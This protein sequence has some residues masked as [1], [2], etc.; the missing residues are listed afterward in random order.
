MRLLTYVL[1]FCS[2]ATFSQQDSLGVKK[3]PKVGLVLSGGGAKGLAHIGALK[4]IEESGVHIDYIGGTSM[5]AIIGGLYASGYTATQLDSI[6]R[7]T[8]FDELIQD[9]LPRSAKSF[10]ERDDAE[11]YAITLP[12]DKFEVSLPSGLSKG[13][14][15]Y[16]YLERLTSHLEDVSD[17]SKL[18]IPFFCVG[19]DVETGETL[20]LEKGSISKSISA[21]GAIPTLFNPVLIDDR[22]IT[23]GGVTNNYPLDEL[24]AKGMDIIIGVDVQ[25][26][27]VSRNELKS[28]FEIL[29]QVNNFE[30]IYKMRDKSKRTDVYINPDIK[31]FTV[32]SFGEGETIVKRGEDAAM[33]KYDKLR[34]IAI[35][36]GFKQ[37]IPQRIGLKD[38]IIIKNIIISGNRNYPRGY[39]K[40]R[41]KIPDEEKIAFQDLNYG[42]NNL[43]ATGNFDRIDYVLKP[44][45]DGY[46]VR[47]NVDESNNSTLLR[48]SL[49]YDD[50]YQTG[51]L[52]NITQKRL[53]FGNDIASL[54]MIVG[55]NLRYNFEYYIDKGIYW[56]I[57]ARSRIN[58]FNRD[59]NSGFLL[60]Q[61]EAE[62]LPSLLINEFELDV[63]DFT[64]QIYAET[65]FRKD[66]KIGVG[67]EQKYITLETQTVADSDESSPEIET[68]NFTS[69][70]GYV[71]LD[72]YDDKYFPN[73]GFFAEGKYNFYAFNSADEVLEFED[74]SIAKGVLGMAINPWDPVAI[75]LSTEAGFRLGSNENLALN[76]ALGGYGSMMINNYV[77]FYGYDFLSLQGDSYIK[78][79]GEIDVELFPKNHLIASYNIANVANDIFED[80][81]WL[82]LPDF[83][84]FALGY[85]LETFLGPINITYSYSPETS[86][87]EW[88]FSLGYW[89]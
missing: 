75:R 57:G 40:S 27:L 86:E 62:D 16:N 34:L 68:D 15:V 46:N 79:L 81:E 12:F 72:T 61:S 36:Q 45:E 14:N 24:K 64:N 50:L 39:I 42:I 88:F 47:I 37:R 10:Y 83:T 54:D 55:D 74:F 63:F 51:I 44:W 11:K 60:S 4:I 67:L 25:D 2:L 69:A 1:L 32:L 33:K 85:G 23:D 20:I 26:S 82:T 41:L 84:G 29:N 30:S 56:S 5:G 8:P 38:S 6:F 66:F 65:L 28:A 53:L 13:Q 70:F 19:T 59:I 87:N 73:K 35:K 9:D 52:V 71:K 43:S 17:F 3:T 78:A 31:D 18:P 58:T 21:S 80:G 49:H 22:L 77:P 7:E 89:F 76:F 48:L